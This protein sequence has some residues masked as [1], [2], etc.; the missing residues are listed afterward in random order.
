MRSLI[1]P[2]L[3]FLLA[4]LI[5]IDPNMVEQWI[6][7]AQEP[8]KPAKKDPTAEDLKRIADEM[9]KAFKA[10]EAA[11]KEI[12]RDTF[13]PKAIVDKVG[14]DPAKLF[15]WVRDK[16]YWV[17]YQGCLRGH[18]GVLMDR[19]GSNLDRAL[20][21]AELL[22]V[23]GHKV[24][25][26]RA[27]ITEA[28]AKG[29]LPKL[30]P[31]LKNP[32]PA[33]PAASK[34][35]L[36]QL[37]EKYAKEYQLDAGE[38]RKNI[39]KVSL[40]AA[41]LAEDVAQ[42]VADQVPRIVKAVGLPGEKDVQALRAR[43]AT[44]ELA[45]L[46]DHWWVQRQDGDGWLDLDPLLPDAEP[47]KALAEAKETI[48]PDKDG[49]PV[50]ASK[51]C[52]EVNFRIV[53]EKWEKNKVTEHAV[54][55]HTLRPSDLFGER[56][57]LAHVPI[58]WPKDLNLF[59]EKDRLAKLRTVILAQQQWCPVLTV[60]ST[61]FFQSGF[62]DS[63]D[64]IATPLAP[65]L[66]GGGQ[67]LGRNI[68]NILG[69][70]KI[71]QAPEGGP[72]T[73]TQLT[74]EWIDYEIR[75]P[76]RPVQ[77]IRRQVFDLL[78]P[79]QRSEGKV[80]KPSITKE[81]Q[82]DRGLSLTGQTDILPVVSRLSRPYVQH[83]A[84][85]N[86][87][88]D[89]PILR[90][91]LGNTN[92]ADFKTMSSLA[93]KVA[94]FPA[95]LY[96]LCMA[97]QGVG[98]F[99][100]DI[101]MNRPNILSLHR[102]PMQK[103]QADMAMCVSF[104]IVANDVAVRSGAGAD[105]FAI[106]LE[107]GILDTNAEALI[108]V[109]CA[110]MDNAADLFAQTSGQTSEW[111]TVRSLQDENWRAVELSADV[112]AR[113]EDDLAAGYTVIVPKKPIAHQG[114]LSSG[115]WRINPRT[116]ETLGIGRQGWGASAAEYIL[117]GAALVVTIVAAAF[118]VVHGSKHENMAQVALCMIGGAFCALGL[119]VFLFALLDPAALLVAAGLEAMCGTLTSAGH[120]AG[121]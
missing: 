69:S 67:E 15:E 20:L 75:S 43:E 4:V 30:R 44:S 27:E 33:A 101:Y 113:I 59:K 35:D 78:G 5:V 45:A 28:Q 48:A 88:A 51:H 106:R 98:K 61:A 54:L 19:L 117:V 24:R 26:A 10:L 119:L 32:V 39:N 1:K 25:L 37:I 97:R 42:R 109:P 102:Y 40:Q 111:V 107:Q 18:T 84:T 6:A 66:G 64:L 94:P 71:G 118:C 9:E 36:D 85:R 110:K 82:L 23:A 92:P 3:C 72:K 90:D 77:K 60:G 13:D 47:G 34:K 2:H 31:V 114:P 105:P 53:I 70:G 68:G 17:P 57:A 96:G 58:Q 12:P 116:G 22:R 80:A 73:E 99:K 56:I 76:G 16:T 120:I 62:T 91:A 81:T 83:L 121:D 63:G 46:R 21:L 89:G 93:S 38:M 8:A 55:E 65:L 49:K 74:A 41:K 87:L 103:G 11:E 104:D 86:F 50:L 29:L 100:D 115:W 112:R 95:Q 108:T 52:H 79:A 7:S 14:R